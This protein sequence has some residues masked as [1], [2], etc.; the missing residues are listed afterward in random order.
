MKNETR[1]DDQG[2]R[3]CSAHA[4]TTGK[5]CRAPA[6]TGAN[7]CI[8][9]GAAQGTPGR[10][11]ADRRNLTELVGPALIR[12][13]DLV[14]DPQTPP[15]VLLAAIRETLDRTGYTEQFSWTMADLWPMVEN[16]LAAQE[17][18]LTAEEKAIRDAR[19]KLHVATAGLTP[20]QVV[21]L[22]GTAREMRTATVEAET[23]RRY[24]TAV[25]PDTGISHSYYE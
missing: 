16:A 17:E 1:R 7:V 23:G 25:D 19:E 10:E 13:H 22:A 24:V 14:T 2:R 5:L 11:V 15:P 4:K 20:A 6:V 18:D 8:R 12:L 21:T 3:L 9:H